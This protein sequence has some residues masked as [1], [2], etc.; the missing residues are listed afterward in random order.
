MEIYNKLVRDKIIDIINNNGR[1][2]VAIYRTL[3]DDELKKELLKKLEEEFLE[4]K[5]AVISGDNNSV[6]EESAD[7]IEVIR[8]INNDDLDSVISKL[9]EKREKRGG[10][11][12]KLFL[13]KVLKK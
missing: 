10:F 9:E 2:E 7:L 12:K 4:L 11:S 13:E 6:V 1:N 8:A 3:S 5:D